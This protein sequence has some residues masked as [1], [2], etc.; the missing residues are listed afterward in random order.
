M[1][2]ALTAEQQAFRNEVRKF[3]E[4]EFPPEMEVKYR[5]FFYTQGGGGEQRDFNWEMAR[6]LGAKGWLSLAWPKEYGG[7][8]L[9]SFQHILVEELAYHK[10]P[11]W[12]SVGVGILAP[13]LLRSGNEEQKKRFLPPIAR[14]EVSWCELLSERD[15]G[16]DLAS[17]QTKA[18]E[19]GDY[20]ILNGQKCWTGGAH[21]ADWGFIL[22]RTD[23]KV[24]PKHRGLSLFLLDMKTPGIS[25]TPIL[26]MAGEHEFNEVFL[27]GVR[28]PK[29]N[30]VG[31][32][33]RGWYVV[34][35]VLDFER[36]VY[37][38]H[39]MA[40]RE[41]DDFIDYAQKT[42]LLDPVM[43]NRVAEL[44]VE[45]EIA[46]LIHHRVVWMQDKGI[47]PNYESSI[48]K[49]YSTE[50]KQKISAMASSALG[51]YGALT[52]GS[53]LAPLHGHVPF[54][55]L[56]AIGYIISMGSS[57]IERVVIAQRGLGLP[58]GHE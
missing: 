49:L 33:N 13:I 42:K 24:A 56:R 35:E 52:E 22:A 30:L 27:D 48:D 55:Y 58:R 9:P 34:M 29:E 31:E 23:P 16:S 3:I 37:P 17:L 54:L 57:E 1:D 25:I 40:R 44:L 19:D 10:C 2:F 51:H 12:D 32:K 43:R 14:G 53:K 20:F 7:R 4:H 11:G 26:N 36:S 15:A 50:L 41:L 45:C 47:V 28:V 39:A 21:E 8:D 6:K 18:I 5:D 38:I 46:R